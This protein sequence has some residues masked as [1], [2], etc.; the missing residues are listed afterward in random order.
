MNPIAVWFGLISY[1]LYLWH[2]PILSYLQIIKE[3]IPHRDA[4]ILA[5]LISILLAWLTYKLIECPI[6]FGFLKQK[7]NSIIIAFFLLV[8]G[9]VGYY[10]S[11]ADWTESKEYEDVIFK[12]KSFEHAFGSSSK[13]LEGKESF[14]FLGNDHDNTVAKLKLDLLP[15]DDYILKISAQ[16]ER[17]AKKGS[18][19]NTQIA[20]LVGPNKSSIYKEYLPEKLKSSDRRYSTLIT[21]KLSDIPNLVVVDPTDILNIKKSTEGL[22]YW[23]TNT[24][25]NQKGAFISFKSLQKRLGLKYPEVQ[26]SLE[27]EHKGDLIGI[28]KLNNFPIFYG[29]NW[30]YQILT[31]TQIYR[32]ELKDQEKTTF[33]WTGRVVNNLALNEM[34]VWV[35]GDSFTSGIRNYIEASFKEVKYLGHWSKKLNTLHEDLSN[36]MK[37]PDLIIIVRVERSF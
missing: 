28:S 24:H 23:R 35:I 8:V 37:K 27:G 4:R 2:W 13:F 32:E 19:T 33:G 36:S 1:P 16:F 20:L 22:L 30:K 18:E 3:E 12:R 29:D 21:N 17:L 15:S 25:W 7:V 10:V 11:N 6:R 26:F 31:K 14:L 9:V 5:V 34:Y